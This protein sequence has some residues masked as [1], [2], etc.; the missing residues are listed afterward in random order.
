MV[1][2]L[3]E[4][5]VAYVEKR[6][7]LRTTC[8]LCKRE[9]KFSILKENGASRCY[10]ASCDFGKRWF[11]DWVSLTMGIP[12]KDARAMLRTDDD[13]QHRVK[14]DE[15][16]QEFVSGLEEREDA[17][18]D[19]EALAWPEFY[20]T[21]ILSPDSAEGMSY[22]ARRGVT[23]EMA[24]KYDMAYSKHYRR[25]YFPIMM[26]G[27]CY[28]YQ[29]RHIDPVEEGLRMRNN[30]GFRRDIL[31]MFAD[32][33][34]GSDFA[35]MAEGPFDALKFDL[36]GSNVCTMGKAVTDKQLDIIKSYG[37]RKLY[38]ALDDDA[39]VEMNE[40][41]DMK[42]FESYYK[43]DVP[44]SV[45]AR[46]AAAGKKADFGECTLEEAKTAFEN[47]KPLGSTFLFH[48]NNRFR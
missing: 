24:S 6:N 15:K 35:I 10:R 4:S 22:L 8:P 21:D 30:D 26:G 17:T 46:C 33:L 5:G 42:T 16:L 12:I 43:I 47:A 13:G 2:I 36:V 9:D 34:E 28:G 23:P 37:I 19:I 20:M 39:A 29:G 40:I 45:V 38:L 31:V 1:A 44:A 27:Y 3:S 18:S 14:A 11:P 41:A 7:T 48:P 32:N 25:V